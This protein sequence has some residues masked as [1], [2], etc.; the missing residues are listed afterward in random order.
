MRSTSSHGI[1]LVLLALGI[2]Q[3]SWAQGSA[4]RLLVWD[5]VVQAADEEDA[6]RWP[7]GVAAASA[8]ELAV[9]DIYDSRLLIFIRKATSWTLERKVP[10]A[11]TPI[12]LAHDGERY[13]VS[14]RQSAGLY[15]V[16][17]DRYQ[18][19][20]IA[21]P[22]GAVPGALAGRVGGG[23]LV[24]DLASSSIVKLDSGGGAA[25]TVEVDGFVTAL[26][27]TP[28]GGFY[29]AFADRAEIRQ[30]GSNDAELQRW[31]VPGTPPV[32]PW[33]SGVAMAPSGDLVVV[34]RHLGRLD[35]LDSS[36]R[37][38]G[39]GSRR[40]WDPGLLRFPAGLALLP[41]NR[42]AVADQGNG[43]V[44]LFRWAPEAAAP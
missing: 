18:L 9:A 40:G 4:A 39:V 22:G 10:L 38:E 21:L 34:D 17:G 36:G 16:E 15:A 24:Y 29:A 3:A 8:D 35:V 7:V 42:V 19:R 26:A 43:R 6:L 12:A 20:R 28:G 11:G 13:A 1:V 2:A 5:E 25:G 44:Q 14:L 41:D 27:A 37:L 33:P 23:F 32:P 31:T 30:Y